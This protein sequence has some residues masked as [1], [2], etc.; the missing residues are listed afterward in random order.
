MKSVSKSNNLFGLEATEGS[1]AVPL[2]LDG[3]VEFFAVLD[4][5]PDLDVDLDAVVFDLVAFSMTDADSSRN[6]NSS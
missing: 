4:V 6:I 1:A 2:D 5:D 3:E